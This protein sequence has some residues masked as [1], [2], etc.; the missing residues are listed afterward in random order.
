MKMGIKVFISYSAEDSVKLKALSKALG[1]SKRRFLPIIIENRKLPG[2]PLYEKVKEGI[3][4]TPFFIPIMT[5]S[6]IKNQWVNQEIGFAVANYRNIFPIV[7]KSIVKRLKGFIHNQIDLPFVFEGNQTSTHK[8]AQQF[9]QCYR[10][11]VRHLEEIGFS[12]AIRPKKVKQGAPY[13]T[14]VHFK[15]K[16]KNAFFTNYIEHVDSGWSTWQWDPNTLSDNRATTPG[17]LHGDIDKKSKYKKGTNDWPVGKY[18]IHTRAYEH[19]VPGE[20]R[21]FILFEK[22]HNFEVI[23]GDS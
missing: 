13:I 18:K 23:D 17:E 4:E 15:G 8:E 21:R 1:K 12:S 11:L 9:L 7:E 14:A 6:S 19:P 2:K 10:D 5:R 3:L 20:L 16:V 22:I